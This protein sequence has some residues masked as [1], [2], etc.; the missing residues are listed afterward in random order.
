[1]GDKAK[2]LFLDHEGDSD[3]DR[4]EDEIAGGR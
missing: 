3:R 1:M 2:A 4:N